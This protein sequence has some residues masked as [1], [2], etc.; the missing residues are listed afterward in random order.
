MDEYRPDIP[1]W[2]SYI[3]YKDKCFFVSTIER[4]YDTPSGEFRGQETLVWDYDYLAKE[5]KNLVF[6]S[7]NIIEHSKICLS[8][9]RTGKFPKDEN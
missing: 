8:L 3:F 4:T 5:R 2:K 6:Q 9:I 1:I 7:G